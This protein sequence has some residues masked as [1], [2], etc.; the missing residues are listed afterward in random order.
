MKKSLLTII[1]CVIGLTAFTQPPEVSFPYNAYWTGSSYSIN[2]QNCQD[3]YFVDFPTTIDATDWELNIIQKG[4]TNNQFDY[5]DEFLA[6]DF[7]TSQNNVTLTFHGA[8]PHQGTELEMRDGHGKLLF[9]ISLEYQE[10]F[11]PEELST[12]SST[13]TWRTDNF[14]DTLELFQFNYFE[15]YSTS[16]IEFE[17]KED[18]SGWQIISNGNPELIIET[19]QQDSP[20]T[21][22]SLYLNMN[23]NAFFNGQ[24]RYTIVDADGNPKFQIA[25]N[26]KQCFL[27]SIRLNS[28]RL[29]DD[30]ILVCDQYTPENLELLTY[31]NFENSNCLD[32]GQIDLF[33]NE[34]AEP[35]Y[36]NQM[37]LAN[38]ILN[39]GDSIYAIITGNY[40]YD[41]CNE[42]AYGEILLESGSLRSNVIQI[43]G[44]ENPQLNLIEIIEGESSICAADTTKLKLK[45]NAAYE[46]DHRWM[47][48]KS[49][50]Y[51]NS[52]YSRFEEDGKVLRV[53]GLG[54][55]RYVQ[56]NSITED[57]CPVVSNLISIT[58]DI[59]CKGSVQGIV[60][61]QDSP[62]EPIGGV[63]VKT[64]NDLYAISDNEGKY[65]IEFLETDPVTLVQV[66]NDAYFT[67]NVAVSYSGDFMNSTN[68]NLSTYLLQNQ[69]LA[70]TLSSTRNRPGF[71]IPYTVTISNRGRDTL[72]AN[73][74]VLLADELTYTV[75]E[76]ETGTPTINGQNLTWQ[77]IKVAPGGSER[78]RFYAVLD[79]TTG[80]GT[81]LES[82]ATLDITDD[83]LT[84]NINYYSATV[85]GSYDPNDKAIK[86]NDL[87]DGYITSETNFEY[88][89]RFQNTGTDT[90]F[91]VRV[92]DVIDTDLDFGTFETISA[93]HNY[94]VSM[95]NDTVTWL[96]ENILLAD[97]NVNEPASHGYIRFSISQKPDNADG[98]EIKNKAFIFFDYND[99]IITNEVVSEVGTEA[100]P[101]EPVLNLESLNKNDVLG[102]YPNP[103][104]DKIFLES[105]TNGKEISIFTGSGILVKEELYHIQGIDISELKSGVYIILIE[106]N[107]YQFIKL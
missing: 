55:Y 41:Y 63:K 34:V 22:F 105:V 30:T 36:S 32:I 61:Q 7:I 69:D 51:Y 43:K 90:A 68:R 3:R 40:F 74:T 8:R 76:G 67:D 62:Y 102:V 38:M 29:K 39:E 28:N 27:T 46:T 26:S 99:P 20:Q 45:N 15:C 23:A 81:I 17:T 71:T 107:S 84:N 100:Y 54:D 86:Y 77:A 60:K 37:K 21:Q 35:V 47:R 101:S 48:N 72:T 31:V 16:R 106:N 59:N 66:D 19:Y 11:Y 65:Q 64:N 56:Y 24:E 14:F 75:K 25:I 44:D 5:I 104:R 103:S 70:V 52:S 57:E 93:S 1:L 92:E 82:T 42:L 12:V 73:T 98:T 2:V 78:I 95:S 85:T 96:F 49:T 6:I 13:N 50:Y 80:L 53:T 4:I 94:S 97:S 89:I 79:R 10:C 33:I 18:V 9:N 91:T 88:T 83:D 58:K 87:E